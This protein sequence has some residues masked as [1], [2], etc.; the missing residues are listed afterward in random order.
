M[1]TSH[2]RAHLGHQA[3]SRTKPQQHPGLCTVLAKFFSSSGEQ[4]KKRRLAEV[5][6]TACEG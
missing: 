2:Q 6:G 1:T 3:F 5:G 4:Q